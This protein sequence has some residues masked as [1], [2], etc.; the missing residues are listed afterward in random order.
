VKHFLLCVAGLNPQVITESLYA[1]HQNQMLVDAV[2]VITT[3]DGREKI[4]AQLLSGKSGHYFRYLQEY[5]IPPGSID[6]GPHTV[7]TIRD[8]Y[9]NE[10]PDILDEYGNERVLKK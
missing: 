5:S 9:G 3:R 2:H 7:H 6:F 10:I 1:L 4:Y 8:E